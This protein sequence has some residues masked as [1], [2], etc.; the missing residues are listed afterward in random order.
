MRDGTIVAV[1]AESIADGGAYASTSGE[2]LKCIALFASGCYEVPNIDVSCY[3]VYTNNIPSGAFRG[4]GA[5]QAQFASEVMVTRLAHALGIDP[6]EIRRKNL[7]R[8]GSI[9]PTQ[10]PLP[11]GVTVR[12]CME[13]ALSA[14]QERMAQP[15]PSLP[16]NIRRGWGVACAIKNLGYSFGFPEQATATV[17]LSGSSQIERAI[18]R[19]G[20]AEVGQGTHLILR[21]IAAQALGLGFDQIEMITNDSSEAPNA[22][23]ASA[24]RLTIMAGRA[25]HDAAQA[26]LREWQEEERPAKATVQYRPPRT[27]ALDPVTTAGVPNYAYGYAAQ[28]A[29]VEVNTLTGEVRVVTLISAHDVGRAINRQQVEGQII[30]GLAQALGYALLEQFQIH[31]G[32]VLT[33]GFST[34][35]L[36]TVLDMPTEIVPII[37]ELGDPNGPYGARGMAELPLVPITGAIASAIHAATGAWVTQQPFTPERVLAALQQAE[38]KATLR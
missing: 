29:E 5:P 14:M 2:V 33:T 36:P 30:G 7:Y 13:A 18:V 32:K 10:H 27:T 6:I 11:R 22:G 28:A 20:A 37:L 17:E 15:Q 8:E 19:V 16:A 3:A 31:N 35:L 26:A 34:Y 12:E 4:F 38:A 1:Q 25:V 9:E 23:S 21:Q 24:S